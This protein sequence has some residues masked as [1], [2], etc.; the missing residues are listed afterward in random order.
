MSGAARDGH[1]HQAHHGS[2]QCTRMCASNSSGVTRPLAMASLVRPE[3]AL[4][5]TDC[6]A[7]LLCDGSLQRASTPF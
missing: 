5:M 1:A 2:Q 4:V 7:V 6:H 3:P